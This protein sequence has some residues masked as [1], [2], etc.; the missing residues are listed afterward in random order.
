ML[1]F[2]V[3]LLDKDCCDHQITA[4]SKTS[5]LR[6]LGTVTT[7]SWPME[8][9]P[10]LIQERV[11][12]HADTSVQRTAGACL[13]NCIASRTGIRHRAYSSILPP[14]QT[15]HTSTVESANANDSDTRLLSKSS[16]ILPGNR[17][18]RSLPAASL[19]SKLKNLTMRKK[20][21]G[22]NVAHLKA[23]PRQSPG[24]TGQEQ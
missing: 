3:G 18:I 24:V 4:D 2:A 20:W 13:H 9:I 21:E 11:I 10:Q 5:H 22:L 12:G 1:F 14:V 6:L 7:K 23:Q 15:A 8:K 16:Y 19:H 17:W